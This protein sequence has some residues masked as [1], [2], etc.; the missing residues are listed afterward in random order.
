MSV[1]YHICRIWWSI[2]LGVYYTFSYCKVESSVA[3]V[4]YFN[5]RTPYGNS[6]IILCFAGTKIFMTTRLISRQSTNSQE[7]YQTFVITLY[8]SI[9]NWE[10][11]VSIVICPRFGWM[12]WKKANHDKDHQTASYRSTIQVL[13]C[14]SALVHTICRS[15]TNAISY[16]HCI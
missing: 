11:V 15:D 9:S 2:W 4:I 10:A 12:C 6:N 7:V 13:Q 14:S 3:W 1:I 8:A 16:L 5:I